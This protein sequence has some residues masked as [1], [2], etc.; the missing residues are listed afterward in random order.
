MTQPPAAALAVLRSMCGKLDDVLAGQLGGAAVTRVTTEVEPHGFELELATTVASTF[1]SARSRRIP[2][3]ALDR[4]GEQ[5]VRAIVDNHYRPLTDIYTK[6][7]RHAFE[8]WEVALRGETPQRYVLVADLSP[9]VYGPF[10]TETAAVQARA[11]E[12]FRRYPDVRPALIMP[13]APE[14]GRRG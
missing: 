2:C 7:I 9:Y 4:G 10:P 1:V 13:L 8:T 5:V 11:R 3:E 6:A 12:E 14:D